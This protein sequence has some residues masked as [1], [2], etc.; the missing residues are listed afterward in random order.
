MSDFTA[1]QGGAHHPV[2][3]PKAEFRIYFA[4]IFLLALPVGLAT[5]IYRIATT[6]RLPARGPVGR[7]WAD[8]R[9]ITPSIFRA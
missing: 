2:R 5:W 1:G 9:A 3:T 8:A 7:A 6:G 4:L